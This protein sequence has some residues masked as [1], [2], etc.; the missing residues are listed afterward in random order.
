MI[1]GTR[2]RQILEG[3]DVDEAARWCGKHRYVEAWAIADGAI[4]IYDHEDP[5]AWMPDRDDDG[6]AD[7]FT[8]YAKLCDSDGIVRDGAM[9]HGEDYPC[10]G[11]AHF[12]GAHICCTSGAHGT[13]SAQPTEIELVTAVP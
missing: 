10:T 8:T 3:K 6:N 4:I 12:A 9:H 5:P 2:L 7:P 13:P 11:H 1:P